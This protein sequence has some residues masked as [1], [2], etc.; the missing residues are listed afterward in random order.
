[1]KL[2]FTKKM[3]LKS[4]ENKQGKTVLK[5][6]S[7][8]REDFVE[9]LLEVSIKNN[10]V[11]KLY[12]S[13]NDYGTATWIK[14]NGIID[15]NSW[16]SE[17]DSMSASHL[18]KHYTALIANGKVSNDYAFEKIIPDVLEK[19][20]DLELAKNIC[21]IIISPRANLIYNWDVIIKRNKQLS[22]NFI[23]TLVENKGK[24]IMSSVL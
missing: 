10:M 14:D 16:E 24:R 9:R 15:T 11:Q 5:F 19:L 7:Y 17:D 18:S 12:F 2:T 20:L 4:V 23:Y 13:S 8:L 22:D 21:K 3:I 1:M 6:V